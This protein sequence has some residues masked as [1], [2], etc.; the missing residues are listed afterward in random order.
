MDKE[1]LKALLEALIF[2]ADHPVSMDRLAGVVEGTERDAIR[3]ALN[4]LVEEYSSARGLVLE[5]IAGGW[6]LRTRPEHAPWIRR[7]FMFGMQ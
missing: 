2:A 5:E 4:E 1:E 6:R 7:L 3:E